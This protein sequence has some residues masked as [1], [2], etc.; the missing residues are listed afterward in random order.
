MLVQHCMTFNHM[1]CV[2]WVSQTA[3]PPLQ[4]AA[5]H[6]TQKDVV[7]DSRPCL[8][9][10][11]KQFRLVNIRLLLLL[12]HQHRRAVSVRPINRPINKFRPTLK[13]MIL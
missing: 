11:F 12:C 1:F 13:N 5:A 7:P 9:A 8:D 2:C 4:L 3:V 6:F 10:V